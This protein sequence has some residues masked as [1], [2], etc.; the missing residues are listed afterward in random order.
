MALTLISIC[1][2]YINT[3]QPTGCSDCSHEFRFSHW[4]QEEGISGPS[5][6][7]PETPSGECRQGVIA[8]PW[9]LA[10]ARLALARI[11][12]IAITPNRQVLH[13]RREEICGPCTTHTHNSVNGIQ[14]YSICYDSWNIFPFCSSW[15]LASQSFRC[16]VLKS[17]TPHVW[18]DIPPLVW[19]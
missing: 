9:I 5:C 11:Q 13:D 16:L 2:P 8:I 12:G 14:M 19:C 15:T 4:W 1:K 7:C 18:S 17:R 10:N 6:T 3:N